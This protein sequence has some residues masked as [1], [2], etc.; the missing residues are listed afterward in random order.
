MS[1]KSLYTVFHS[2]HPPGAFRP[3]L[4]PA[5]LRR[6]P[7]ASGRFYVTVKAGDDLQAAID[8]CP[9]GGAILLDP[10]IHRGPLN[11]TKEVT[12]GGRVLPREVHIYGQGLATLA[13]DGSEEALT[14]SA[15]VSTVDGL[16]ILKGPH[17]PDERAASAVWIKS[18]GL[19]LQDCVVR[20]KS[21]VCVAVSGGEDVSDPLIIG[22]R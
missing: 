18:G 16:I 21:F 22:C 13:C 10:G 20:S 9:P 19:R 8:D 5:G 17:S 14:S 15:S 1:C 7:P 3:R 2:D 11:L 12:R 6:L 4:E